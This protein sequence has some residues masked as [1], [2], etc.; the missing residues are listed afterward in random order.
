MENNEKRWVNI[1][2]PIKSLNCLLFLILVSIPLISLFTRILKELA[3]KKNEVLTSINSYLLF[4]PLILFGIIC[5]FISLIYMIVKNDNLNR[6]SKITS[7]SGIIDGH[8]SIAIITL[9]GGIFGFLITFN[10]TIANYFLGSFVGI[11]IGV[12]RNYIVLDTVAKE[13]EKK[14]IK[15]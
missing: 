3:Q 15:E 4:Y 6:P 7:P 13:L 2:L 14:D 11:I 5:I 9:I 12:V 8:M 1:K 10:L